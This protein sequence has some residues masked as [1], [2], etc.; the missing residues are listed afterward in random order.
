M[1]TFGKMPCDLPDNPFWRYFLDICAIPH[2]SGHEAALR[3]F[4][5]ERARQ[6]GLG[7]RTDARGNLAVDRP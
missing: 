3:E 1:T 4:L 7:V 6:A 2:P 5:A